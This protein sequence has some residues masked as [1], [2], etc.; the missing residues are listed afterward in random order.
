MNEAYLASKGAPRTSPTKLSFATEQAK[1][2]QLPRK[3]ADG[4]GQ[5]GKEK[6][7]KQAEGIKGRTQATA[8]RG[9]T[10]GRK[11]IGEPHRVRGSAMRPNAGQRLEEN[12]RTLASNKKLA[13]HWPNN[14][15]KQSSKQ[16]NEKTSISAQG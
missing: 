3:R 9:G 4:D 15:S 2:Q 13:E 6:G 10:G 16:I 1:T 5:M 7:R 8:I 14:E 11:R 12:D